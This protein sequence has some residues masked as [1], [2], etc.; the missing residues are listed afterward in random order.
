MKRI[1]LILCFLCLIQSA[2][3]EDYGLKKNVAA[4]YARFFSN[5]GFSA[6]EI[7]IHNGYWDLYDSMKG[8]HDLDLAVLSKGDLRLLRNAIYARH[9][10]IF[11]S[12]D[13]QDWFSRF[14]C[15]KPQ[16]ADVDDKLTWDDKANIRA[17]QTYENPVPNRNVKAADLVGD[18]MGGFPSP[19]GSVDE[20]KIYADGTIEFGYNSMNPRAAYM[21][22]GT[23]RMEDGYLVVM[24]TEQR[25]VLGGYFME[26]WGSVANDIGNPKEC[27]VVY[28]KPVRA[29]FPVGEMNETFHEWTVKN[30]LLGISRKFK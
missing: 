7:I 21:A 12:W 14:P 20:L 1:I 26:G 11:K 4:E 16:Y 10:L 6:A 15:Y 13:L 22:K 19:A 8:F 9:G 3:G 23:Y 29:V 17:I 30:F 2:F 25:L 5:L 28:D 27:R 18:W 24:L